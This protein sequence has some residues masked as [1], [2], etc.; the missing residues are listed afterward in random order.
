MW[1]SGMNG[2]RYVWGQMKPCTGLKDIRTSGTPDSYR[3]GDVPRKKPRHICPRRRWRSMLEDTARCGDEKK[4][5]KYSP[6]A[7]RSSSVCTKFFF[8]ASSCFRVTSKESTFYR[9]D[10][11]FLIP[12]MINN[13]THSFVLSK[14]ETADLVVNRFRKR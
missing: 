2:H 3:N 5:R 4:T 10:A 13:S 12:Q 9:N 1:E 11:L 6:G 14:G 7:T 8:S